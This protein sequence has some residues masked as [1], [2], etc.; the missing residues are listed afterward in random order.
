M[1]L[2]L[3]AWVAPKST[4]TALGTKTMSKACKC[5]CPPTIWLIWSSFKVMDDVLFFSDFC[6]YL[7]LLIR[8]F[9][10]VGAC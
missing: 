4:V 5:I 1:R 9:P 8:Y 10:Y 7:F 2:V 3:P 6:S